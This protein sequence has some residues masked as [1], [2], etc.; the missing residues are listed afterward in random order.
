MRLAGRL[1]RLGSNTNDSLV[2]GGY[3]PLYSELLR[4]G[5]SSERHG[6]PERLV[7]AGPRITRNVD[8]QMCRRHVVCSASCTPVGNAIAWYYCEKGGRR[9]PAFVWGTAALPA[10]LRA[11]YRS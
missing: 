9:A 5:R 6:F 7:G 10:P 4:A 1:R 11:G 8:Q 2:W 3:E